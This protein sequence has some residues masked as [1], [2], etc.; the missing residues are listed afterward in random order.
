MTQESLDFDTPEEQLHNH[1]KS[2]PVVVVKIRYGIETSLFAISADKL[3]S[4]LNG[5]HALDRVMTPVYRLTE[6]R[7][8]LRKIPFL[9]PRVIIDPKY[10]W[11]L[12][13]SETFYYISSNPI[14]LQTHSIVDFEFI[15]NRTDSILTSYDNF[16]EE[17]YNFLMDRYRDEFVSLKRTKKL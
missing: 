2:T 14:Y 1:F 7:A 6:S 16:I 15:G 5:E 3:Q 10:T 12:K 8:A 13:T 11:F 9:K 17:S 4:L